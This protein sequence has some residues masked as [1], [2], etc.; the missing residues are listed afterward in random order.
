MVVPH[1]HET[2]REEQGNQHSQ[3]PQIR[4]HP[5]ICKATV[6]LS[7]LRLYRASPR[8]RISPTLRVK[9]NQ[10]VSRPGGPTLRRLVRH[11]AGINASARMAFRPV[12]CKAYGSP[13]LRRV[14]VPLPSLLSSKDNL[15]G[16]SG[17]NCPWSWAIRPLRAL[18]ADTDS[19][20]SRHIWKGDRSLRLV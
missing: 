4:T 18:G 1:R 2:P 12:W 19:C 13:H 7:T 3:R 15:P 11:R 9:R 16:L 6:L 20:P 14:R 5:A 17:F 10:Y 8:N